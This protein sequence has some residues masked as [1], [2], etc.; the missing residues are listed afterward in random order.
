MKGIIGAVKRRINSSYKQL[1]SLPKPDTYRVGGTYYGSTQLYSSRGNMVEILKNC[2]YMS[3]G[4][5]CNTY[6]STIYALKVGGAYTNND[7]YWIIRKKL[8]QFIDE[9]RQEIFAAGW[10]IIDD[11]GTNFSV[12]G[13]A[14]R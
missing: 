13:I 1:C 7:E 11:Y 3:Y 10:A 5:G 2:D 8:K 6:Y 14:R 4:Y 9:H 12:Y